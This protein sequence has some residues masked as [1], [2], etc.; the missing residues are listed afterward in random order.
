ML[1]GSGL[2]ALDRLIRFI[3]PPHQSP[4]RTGAALPFD[5]MFRRAIVLGAGR[6]V[7]FSR[8]DLAPHM[9]KVGQVQSGTREAFQRF[10]DKIE[11]YEVKRELF[12]NAKVAFDS[13]RGGLEI[14]YWLQ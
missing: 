4:V 14:W 1:T 6:Q 5:L 9:V 13:E 11:S 8:H 12:G 2:N 7:L 10:L 3:Q